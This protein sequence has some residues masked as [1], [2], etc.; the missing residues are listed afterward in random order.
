MRPISGVDPS[1]AG[2]VTEGKAPSLVSV[3]VAV[4]KSVV[5]VFPDSTPPS[6]ASVKVRAG[7]VVENDIKATNNVIRTG[8][9][10][11]AN[12]LL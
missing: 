1:E 12:I 8:S 5:R 6:D 3:S 10:N 7:A 11:T 4:L 9:D 2:S